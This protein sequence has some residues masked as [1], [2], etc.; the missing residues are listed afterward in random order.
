MAPSISKLAIAVSAGLQ[1]ARPALAWQDTNMCTEGGCNDCPWSTTE[2]ETGYPACR[3]YDTSEFSADFPSASTGG[4]EVFFDI[5]QPDPGCAMIIRSPAGTSEAGCGQNVITAHNAACAFATLRN[6]FMLQ[7]CCGDGDCEAAGAS[8]RD[9]GDFSIEDG[10]TIRVDRRGGVSGSGALS[11]FRNGTML[12]PIEE[13]FPPEHPSRQGT[14]AKQE[15]KKS[16]RT[17]GST[18][19]HLSKRNCEFTQEGA[20]Y[21]F[22]GNTRVIEGTYR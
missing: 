13:G 20:T 8:K 15:E 2:S 18:I 11:L 14:L 10:G 6:T 9:L 1:F 22:P 5:E 19:P 3:I 7:W 4:L 21:T 17:G 16:K 12:Q